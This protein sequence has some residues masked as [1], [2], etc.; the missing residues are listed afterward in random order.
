MLILWGLGVLALPLHYV[1]D[2]CYKVHTPHVF[3]AWG[4]KV[5]GA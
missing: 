3:S 1:K 5:E 4:V 2:G